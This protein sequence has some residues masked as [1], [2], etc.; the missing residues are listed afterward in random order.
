MAYIVSRNN[1]FYVVAYDGVDHHTGKERRRWH[2]AGRSRADAE[3][4]A[5]SMTEA[6]GVAIPLGR[7]AVTL[8]EFFAANWLP[9][10]ARHV[11]PTTS[12]RYAWMIEHCINPTFGEVP[13]RSIRTEHIDNLY[14]SLLERGGRAGNGL[15]PKT[16]HEVHVIIRSALNDAVDCGLLRIKAATNA[17]PPRSQC[18]PRTGPATWSAMQLTEFLQHAS[19]QR[20]YPTLPRCGHRHATR[21][22]RRTAVVGLEPDRTSAIDQPVPASR[23]WPIHRVRTQ[24]AN[25]STVH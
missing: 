17:R 13:L 10:R 14:T 9:R 19:R 22:D 3:A 16:L 18:R 2:P 4:V 5:A 7:D 25:Q 24:D 21:R 23:R 20:L 1:R 12:Y 8:G 11:R 15:A 6:S